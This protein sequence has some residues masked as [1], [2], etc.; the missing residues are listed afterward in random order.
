M[1]EIEYIKNIILLLN[2]WEILDHYDGPRFYSCRDK[3][4]Q[5]YLVYWIDH[6]EHNDHWIYSKISLSRYISLK[7]GFIPIYDVLKKP[8][9]NQVY[10][11]KTGEIFDVVTLNDEQIDIEW[12]PEPDDYL[13]IP[14][15]SLPQKITSPS[16]EASASNRQVLDLS[17]IK[18]NKSYEIGCGRL[19]KVLDSLQNLV[20]A[21]ACGAERNIKKIPKYIIDDNELFFTGVFES[22]FGIRLQSNFSP[23]LSSEDDINANEIL[24]HLLSHINDPQSIIEY[25]KTFNVLSRTRLKKFLKVLYSNSYSLNLDWGHP[26]GK[27][28]KSSVTHGTIKTVLDILEED[29]DGS[30]QIVE[31]DARLVGVDVESDFFA[32]KTSDSQIIKGELSPK[33]DVHHFEVP[34]SVHAT[35]EETCTINPL[36]DYEKWDY[37][38][39]DIQQSQA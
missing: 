24:S 25:L 15:S 11:V 9:E 22:S 7:N 17:L 6:V 36:T 2:P 19:G 12:L 8:E 35:V 20:N 34:S 32:I 29:E 21:L 37:V 18:I 28:Y 1:N 38:L 10:F 14:T 5:I 3:T 27:C 4:G 16:E 33:L 39:L 30:T 31:Y 26:T 13:D 23:L